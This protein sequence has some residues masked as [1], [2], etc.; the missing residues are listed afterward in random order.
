MTSSRVTNAM[1]LVTIPSE[2]IAML[3][4]NL[5]QKKQCSSPSRR[6]KDTSRESAAM[7]NEL[8]VYAPGQRIIVYEGRDKILATVVRAPKGSPLIYYSPDRSIPH[9]G[10]CEAHIRQVRKAIVRRVW[11]HP[12]DLS[13]KS[14][15][16]IVSYTKRDGWREFVEVS[17]L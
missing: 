11:I 15:Q 9:T 5:A 4:L 13:S 7:R 14:H 12:M 2:D 1:V 6:S 16:P 10:P 8:P 17:K 3:D